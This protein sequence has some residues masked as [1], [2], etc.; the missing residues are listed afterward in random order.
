MPASVS[1]FLFLNHRPFG[2]VC[3]VAECSRVQ[4]CQ[5]ISLIINQDLRAT[6][7]T[8]F[9]FFF[10]FYTHLQNVTNCRF[11]W[12]LMFKYF[13]ILY[14]YQYKESC[15]MLV[16]AEIRNGNKLFF[17]FKADLHCYSVLCNLLI[18][19]NV[20][21][22]LWCHSKTTHLKAHPHS[23]SCEMVV[24]SHFY[25][26]WNRGT[27]GQEHKEL[28]CYF[29]TIMLQIISQRFHNEMYSHLIFYLFT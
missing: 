12:S 11:L 8:F 22:L 2:L 23:C 19:Y 6:I 27:G 13:K 5:N 10:F 4:V 1:F 21:I 16:A 18:Y 25:W 24:S 9:F 28:L 3:V 14:L 15:I 20:I 17:F 26:L 7:D 29:T